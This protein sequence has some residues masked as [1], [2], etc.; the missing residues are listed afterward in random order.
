MANIKAIQRDERIE[1][2]VSKEEKD[3]IWKYAE[4][5]GMKPSRM[6]RNIVLME[7]ES[8]LRLVDVVAVKAYRKYLEIT[9]PEFLKSL[10][11]AE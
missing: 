7:A 8:K 3:L 10:D 2:I 1:F 11:E 4:E 6:I 5:V 9:D